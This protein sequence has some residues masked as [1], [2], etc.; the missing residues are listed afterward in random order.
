MI[1]FT[2]MFEALKGSRYGGY[3]IVESFNQDQ[4]EELLTKDLAFIQRQLAGGR[5]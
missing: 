4:P 3:L 5:R 1:D 2:P